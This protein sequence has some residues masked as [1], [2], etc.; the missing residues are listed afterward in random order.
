MTIEK[1][2][3]LYED[4]RKNFEFMKSMKENLETKSMSH[5]VRLDSSHASCVIINNTEFE[6]DF[7]R[8][9]RILRRAT[10]RLQAA[11]ARIG[12]TALQN[13]LICKYF[14]GF[15]N[16][17]TALYF[18]YCERHIYRLLKDAKK[19]L[20]IELKKL[21]PRARR[22]EKNKVYRKSYHIRE[23]KGA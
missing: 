1:Y 15:K 8:R 19:K 11:I 9:E 20:Y 22:G 6:R 12:D 16:T 4:Y 3:K 18:S 10:A 7:F 14:Y 13:V 5:P 2:L 17:E 21:M 23:E